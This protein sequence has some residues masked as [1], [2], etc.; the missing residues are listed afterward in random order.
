MARSLMAGTTP[1]GVDDRDNAIIAY[2]IKLTRLPDALVHDDV[3]ALRSYGLND[4]AILEVNLA[5][6]YMNFVN[7]I[8]SG[9]GVEL[10]LDLQTYTR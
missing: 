8:A 10:E 5:V 1:E 2:S 6:A 7:R 9:L 4:R 3:A